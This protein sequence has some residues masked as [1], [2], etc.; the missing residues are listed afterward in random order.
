M[1][2]SE[3]EADAITLGSKT[4]VIKIDEVIDLD[5]LILPREDERA[6]DS[7]LTSMVKIQ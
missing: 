2:L 7:A 4:R 6:P 3:N 5:V 1:W